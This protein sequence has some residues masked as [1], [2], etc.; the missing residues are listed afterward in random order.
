MSLNLQCLPG[1][2]SASLPSTILPSPPLLKLSLSTV[3]PGLAVCDDSGGGTS[4]S[5]Y[6]GGDFINIKFDG[7]GFPKGD[8]GDRGLQMEGFG[9]DDFQRG[10]FGTSSLV[11]GGYGCGLGGACVFCHLYLPRLRHDCVS[12]SE[13]F[14]FFFSL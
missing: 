13:E 14:L 7:D 1:H 4:G 10:G 3:C 12:S 8:F 2:L 5:G 9:E 6:D 11:K